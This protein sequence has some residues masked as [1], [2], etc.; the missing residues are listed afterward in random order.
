MRTCVLLFDISGTAGRIALKFSVLLPSPDLNVFF[1]QAMGGA[2]SHVRI[3]LP[4]RDR[5]FNDYGVLLVIIPIH[6]RRHTMTLVVTL[7]SGANRGL[8]R[9]NGKSKF[10]FS[11][12]RMVIYAKNL[13]FSEMGSVVLF[14]NVDERKWP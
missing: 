2:R 3:A 11:V 1:L 14:R 4:F 8:V 12:F 5:S 10:K 13:I 6:K 9:I 7:H